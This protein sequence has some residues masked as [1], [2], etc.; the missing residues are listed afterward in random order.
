MKFKELDEGAGRASP[1][2]RHLLPV[3]RRGFA[4]RDR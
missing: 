3:N 4:G 1:V 2:D